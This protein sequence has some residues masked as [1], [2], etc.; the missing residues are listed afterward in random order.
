MD[1]KVAQAR[2]KLGTARPGDPRPADA[3][4]VVL[5]SFR[6]P[7]SVRDEVHRAA[8]ASGSSSQTWL[9]AAVQDAAQATLNPHGR[10]AAELARNL[11]RRL[12]AA[13][14]DGSYRALVLADQDPDLT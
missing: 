5:L 13:I 14:D 3:D 6:V 7:R 8:A 2:S 12:L 9:R 1:D 10:L 11:R 4:E